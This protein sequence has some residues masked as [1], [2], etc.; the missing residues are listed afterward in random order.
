[1]FRKKLCVLPAAFA[2]LMLGG[3][4]RSTPLVSPALAR[5]S[6]QMPNR[7]AGAFFRL[8]SDTSSRH[9]DRT[10]R[11]PRIIGGSD[12]SPGDWGFMA[13]VR[14]SMRTAILTSF[15]LGPSSSQPS[16]SRQGIAA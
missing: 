15:V 13:F 7:V 5:T 12:A 6:P 11:Q 3:V 14:I 8:W 9:L 2:A 4:L 16:F 10:G 1:M